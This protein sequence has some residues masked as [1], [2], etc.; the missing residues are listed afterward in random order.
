MKVKAVY[1][2]DLSRALETARAIGEATG[3]PVI[4]DVAFRETSFGAWEGRTA[5]EVRSLFPELWSAWRTGDP[6]VRPP[7]GESYEEV[8]R[9]VIHR[10]GELLREAGGAPLALVSHGQ[11]LK[12]VFCW[13]LRLDIRQ[14]FRFVVDNGTIHRVVYDPVDDGNVECIQFR[15]LSLNERR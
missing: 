14:R 10:L 9:R 6:A 8:Y 15:L 2:S 12:A 4:P 13:A 11:A 1:T 5:E 3:A 7:G